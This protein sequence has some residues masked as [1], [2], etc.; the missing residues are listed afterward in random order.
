MVTNANAAVILLTSR[1][2][3]VSGTR[4]RHLLLLL[5]LLTWLWRGQDAL[6][7]GRHRRRRSA[8]IGREV[9][10]RQAVSGAR[11]HVGGGTWH[12]G[13]LVADDKT[14]ADGQGREVATV[15]TVLGQMLNQLQADYEATGLSVVIATCVTYSQTRRITTC[16]A[17][18]GKTIHV[19][20][21]II[22]S[23]WTMSTSASSLL[24]FVIIGFA[25]PL[26]PF[27]SELISKQNVL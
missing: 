8:V 16:G 23:F 25:L 4:E 9:S 11:R 26:F 12:A 7:R 24:S 18:I 27:N 17:A 6:T 13:R 22:K 20:R 3:Q 15:P 1:R 10:P 5:L 14:N 2:V 21:C 19:L